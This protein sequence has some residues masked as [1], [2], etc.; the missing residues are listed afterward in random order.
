MDDEENSIGARCLAVPILDSEGHAVAAIGLSGT[1]SQ[2]DDETIPR[3]AD[4]AMDAARR[5]SRQLGRLPVGN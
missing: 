4:L 5:I 1:V 3:V 2:L